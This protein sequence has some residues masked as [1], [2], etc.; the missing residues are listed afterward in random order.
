M[1]LVH[2]INDK[3]KIRVFPIKRVQIS[4]A[5]FITNQSLGYLTL[6]NIIIAYIY[7]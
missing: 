1:H 4:I 3:D 6:F 5:S 7:T 2:S